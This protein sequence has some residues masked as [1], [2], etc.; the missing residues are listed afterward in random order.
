MTY[1][2]KGIQ[3][4]A[5]MAAWGGGGFPYVPR[6]SAA[7]S[8]GNQGRLLVF[9]LGGGPVPIPPELPP[10]EVAPAAPKQ[11][12]GVSPAMIAQG[13]ALF[14]QNCV[15]CHANQHRSITPDLRRMAEGTHQAFDDIVLRGLLVANGMPRWD[16]VLSAADAKA[17]HA[18]LIDAQA[19]TRADELDKRKRGLAL[20]AP[21]L[22]ILSNY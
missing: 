16:D 18:Y 5:V 20:D 22:A 4:V 17:I 13:Q 7:Y 9:R 1:K 3:Y 8:R 11:L 6:Y 12:P 10:L 14:F 19:K 15:L 2:V 21:S